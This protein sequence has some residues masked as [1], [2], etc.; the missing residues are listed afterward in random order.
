MNLTVLLLL[1]LPMYCRSQN[2]TYMVTVPKVTRIGIDLDV[3]ITIFVK[4]PQKLNIVTLFKTSSSKTVAG[5]SR[6]FRGKPGKPEFIKLKIPDNTVPTSGYQ[7]HIISTGSLVF[8]KTFYNIRIDG[9]NSSLFIQTD[10]PVYRPSDKVQFR[11][12]G[13]KPSLKVVEHPLDVVIFDTLG[14]RVK[15]YLKVTDDFGVFGGFLQLSSVTKLGDWQI[16]V[17]Q[18]GSKET[19][20]FAVEE[21]ELPKFEVK[22]S[23]L[24]VPIKEDNDFVIR[25]TA[26]YTFGK[27]VEGIA[28]IQIKSTSSRVQDIYLERNIKVT[29]HK[30][31]YLER[32]IK[33]HGKVDIRISTWDL[34]PQFGEYFR[35]FAKVN[36]TVTGKEANDT[37]DFQFQTNPWKATF[38]PGIPSTFK[39]GLSYTII[40][41]IGNADGSRIRQSKE[42]AKLIISYEY[43]IKDVSFNKN[44]VVIQQVS[45]PVIANR[46]RIYVIYKK[47]YLTTKYISKA[48]S[49][50]S[51]Y[52]QIKTKSGVT[53]QPGSNLHIVIQIT[54]RI[55]YCNYQIFAKGSLVDSGLFKM[56]M[57]YSRKHKVSI[58][59]DMTPTAKMIVYY[60]RADGEIVADAV[61]FSV[62]DVLKNKVT[63]KFDKNMAEPADRVVLHVTADPGSLVNV[64]AVDKSILLL[65]SANDITAADVLSELKEYDY[66]YSPSL[67]NWETL[68]T[69][70]DN[71]RDSNAVFS[72]SGMYVLTDCNLVGSPPQRNR[73]TAPKR[74]GRTTTQS[75]TSVMMMTQAMT[76]VPMGV[77]ATPSA[78]GDSETSTPSLTEPQ[79]KRSKFP[80]TWLWLNTTTSNVTFFKAQRSRVTAPPRRFG[81]RTTTQSGTTLVMMTETRTTVIMSE[82]ANPSASDDSSTPSL[83]EPQRKR[84]KF[85][86]TWLWM[87]TT[88][89][90][91]GHAS[92]ETIVPDTIT[93]WITSS[94]AVN[95]KTGFGV[96]ANANI[97]TFQRFFIRLELPYSVIRGEILILQTTVFNYMEEDLNVHVSLSKNENI[98]FADNDG[99]PI[100]SP[101]KD[102]QRSI[103]DGGYPTV[104]VPKDTV[105]SVYFPIIP[106][107]IG[108]SLIDVTA[109]TITVADA[110]QRQ[111]LVKPEGIKQNYNIPIPIDLSNERY[112]STEVDVTFPPNVIN[113][114]QFIKVS[115]IGDIIGKT[116]SGIEDLLQM[117]YGC[118]EQNLVRFVPN[119][120][121]SA[122]L[123]VTGRLTDDIVAK[124]DK[125][126]TAGYQRQ[127]SYARHDGSF[128]AFGNS[129][130]Q[131][132]TWLTSFVLKSFAQAAESTY[133]DPE[134]IR[135][136]TYF[137]LRR[138][139]SSGEFK[140]YGTVYSKALQGGSAS[141]SASL[142][143]YV[144]IAFEE[145][146]SQNQIPSHM[147]NEVNSSIRRGTLHI[148]KSLEQHQNVSSNY[149]Y[150][151]IICTYALTLTKTP[152]SDALLKQIEI[153]ANTTSGEKFW[154]LSDMEAASIQPYSHW[155][156]PHT[157]VRA[158]DIEITSY[159]LLIYN[160]KNDTANG[161]KVVKWLNKQ[162]N[163][164]GGFISTQETVITLQAITGLAEKVYTRRFSASLIVTGDEGSVHRFNVGNSNSLVLQMGDMPISTRRVGVEARGFGFTMVE[165]SVFFNVPAELRK[166]AFSLDIKILNDSVL[167]FM[168]QICFSW[169]R[170][171]KS[172]M[173]YIEITKPTGMETDI[174]SL[175]T[176]RT[177]GL[178]KKKEITADQLNLYFD[179]ITSKEMC[180]DININRVSLVAKQK[181][182]PCRISEY[183]EQSNEFVNNGCLWI[184][185]LSIKEGEF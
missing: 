83:T 42:K 109:R 119:V 172:T 117:S 55:H 157:Q 85:P 63:L 29:F 76:T 19:K 87:N 125:F 163:P 77:S 100:F 161:M 108:T 25:V 106:V 73:V 57:R 143:A 166:P 135:K 151:L 173:G 70:P 48:T 15:Q 35:I 175:N 66:T 49:P 156:P 1:F 82:T 10:R 126:L 127:L 13:L 145:A 30:Y 21:Y 54:E 14:N 165:V 28:V 102:G 4:V 24:D 182:V 26:V 67:S 124:I 110:V 93:Q 81:R 134:V 51:N 53:V 122:Y 171:K 140:E 92:I 8:H 129:D 11:V 65:R 164:F 174:G 144:I 12:F 149:L 91:N 32:N 79:R 153:M 71:G 41:K 152:L 46:G 62:Q 162:R 64:L 40:V 104:L 160:L 18:A 118:G 90:E 86:E 44:G 115:V 9:K 133:I 16:Q 169:L 158:L 132:S 139:T 20:K 99:N 146:K 177:Y 56:K 136:A 167:G 84:S 121:V 2:C 180:I 159:V 78:L 185:Q 5:A 89:S 61:T 97:T 150:E 94:F 7:L 74:F 88:T 38:S 123:N 17:S 113:D 45:F 184:N 23:L 58:T 120:F 141:S 60:V 105:R 142:T 59:Y 43:S 96:S 6:I 27:P 39:P 107:R 95:K 75:Q 183:Y 36:E 103:L 22:V 147:V 114:S 137:L 155:K 168:L 154:Q 69:I 101:G 176:S 47:K 128:S 181:P 37:E 33:I 3:A 31:I 170:G 179:W 68:T 34:Y 148:T 178:Y 50:S 80:E 98:S 111:L 130:R 116:L 72:N 138:Q 131:G 52:L 112:Y